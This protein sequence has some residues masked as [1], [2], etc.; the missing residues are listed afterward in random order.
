MTARRLGRLAAQALKQIARS[1]SAP[2]YAALAN[3]PTLG[4]RMEFR[5]RHRNQCIS[6]YQTISYVAFA[7]L[8][9]TRNHTSCTVGSDAR[10]NSM[11]TGAG[12]G[13]PRSL[14]RSLVSQDESV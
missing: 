12:C 13:R 14:R 1:R 6:R 5:T 2:L 11:A 10:P 4:Y 8:P 9:L 7:L 3:M